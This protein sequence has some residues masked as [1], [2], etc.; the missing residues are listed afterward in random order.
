MSPLYRWEDFVGTFSFFIANWTIKRIFTIKIK[1]EL[2]LK[3]VP[4][5]VL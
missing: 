4:Q 3:A 5:L 1:E 2:P